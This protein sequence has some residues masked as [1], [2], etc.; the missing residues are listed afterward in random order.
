MK[1]LIPYLAA[2]VFGVAFAAVTMLPER[3]ALASGINPGRGGSSSGAGAVPDFV[4]SNRKVQWIY[5]GDT[6]GGTFSTFQLIGVTTTTS[7]SI[8]YSND[9]A[10][11]TSRPMVKG[12]VTATGTQ[13]AWSSITS[14][15]KR[16]YLPK[17]T[18]RVLVASVG[19]ANSQDRVI[20][21]G[22]QSVAPTTTGAGQVCSAT[23]SG[24]TGAWVC[25][26]NATLAGYASGTNWVY[27]RGDGVA[28][29]NADS[30]IAVT[31][32]T[33]TFVVD[34]SV[35]GQVTMSVDGAGAQTFTTNLGTA[36]T[37]I[38]PVIT[39]GTWATLAAYSCSSSGW[40]V[41]QT[42]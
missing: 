4:N 34:Y 39:C 20:Q 18:A 24:T 26:A 23:A 42:Y 7:A 8:A 1:K 28:T 37:V 40:Q 19:G 36:T 17:M 41:S 35:A 30:G 10:S 9:V 13:A 27:V 6:T 22:L 16:N 15:T 14:Y 12:A 3:A 2:V 38:G 5:L 11:D 25:Y 33:H 31:T 21:V 32:G 29:L